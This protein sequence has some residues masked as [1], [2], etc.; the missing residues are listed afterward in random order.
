MEP[1]YRESSD[2]Q[3]NLKY[4]TGIMAPERYTAGRRLLNRPMARV[5]RKGWVAAGVHVRPVLARSSLV[6]SLQ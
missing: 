2:E 4:G 6:M 3:P 1:H 5:V